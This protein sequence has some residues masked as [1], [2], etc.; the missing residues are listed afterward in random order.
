MQRCEVARC[1]R[2]FLDSIEELILKVRLP[3]TAK[4]GDYVSESGAWVGCAHGSGQS[5]AACS[6]VMGER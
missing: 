1:R 3:L 5:D 4:V 6:R 2:V